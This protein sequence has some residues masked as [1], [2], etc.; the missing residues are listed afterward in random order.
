MPRD[1]LWV[2]SHAGPVITPDFLA[3]GMAV[4]IP[5]DVDDALVLPDIVVAPG[6]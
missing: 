2:L 5:P 3:N 6:K 1:M 4:N